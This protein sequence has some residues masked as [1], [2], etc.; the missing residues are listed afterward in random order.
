MVLTGFRSPEQRAHFDS[1]LSRREALRIGGTLPTKQKSSGKRS[2]EARRKLEK[3]FEDT[4]A[5]ALMAAGDQHAL[6]GDVLP[7]TTPDDK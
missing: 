2:R 3:L 5:T 4:R 1:L 6:L 7:K